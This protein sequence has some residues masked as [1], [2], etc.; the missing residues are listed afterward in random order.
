MTRVN[1]CVELSVYYITVQ[2][3]YANWEAQDTVKKDILGRNEI[4]MK[5][6]V[7]RYEDLKMKIVNQLG[8][9]IIVV[10]TNTVD[11]GLVIFAGYYFVEL[12]MR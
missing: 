10:L 1:F 6:T 7:D 8:L 2:A 12:C 5:R 3:A 4:Y 11:V 9:R